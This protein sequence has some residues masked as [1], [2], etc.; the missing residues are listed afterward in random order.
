METHHVIHICLCGMQQ[1]IYIQNVIYFAHII[2]DDSLQVEVK[3][4]FRE[5]ERG[6]DKVTKDES[7]I[8]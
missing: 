4:G 3:K 5:R 8:D 2:S 6:K 7:H 1:M